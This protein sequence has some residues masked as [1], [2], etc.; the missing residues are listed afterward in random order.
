MSATL[1]TSD[2]ILKMDDLYDL[3]CTF[4]SSGIPFRYEMTEAEHQ[5][6]NHVRGRYSIAS[7]IINNISH[8]NTILFD[9]PFGMSEALDDDQMPSK[10]VMLSDDTAL[11][12]LFFWLYNEGSNNDI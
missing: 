5:W 7:W 3:Q 6:L 8:E 4:S 9:C 1:Y 10:A 2:Q 12:K 11:Q